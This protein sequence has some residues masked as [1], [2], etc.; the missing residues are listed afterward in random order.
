[1]D[2]SVRR[3][4]YAQQ[5]DEAPERVGEVLSQVEGV[6]RVSL[7]GSGEMASPR[8]GPSA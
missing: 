4:A 8:E 3:A 1:M 6:Q 7:F 5:L 2:V